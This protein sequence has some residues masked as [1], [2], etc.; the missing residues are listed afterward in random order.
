MRY[1]NLFAISALTVVLGGGQSLLAADGFFGRGG[2]IEIRYDSRE[3]V[4]YENYDLRRDYQRVEE[5][6]ADISRD[7]ARLDCH[8]R[9]GREYLA[10]DDAR[11]LARDQRMLNDLM[12]HIE[13][14]RNAQY[15]DNRDYRNENRD[16]DYRSNDNRDYRNRDYRNNDRD[17]QFNGQVGNGYRR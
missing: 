16:R 5:L 12:A 17:R 9:E 10:A 7:R 13:R 11:D 14:D 2:H 1:T 4:R 3:P 8:I 6:R 15:R